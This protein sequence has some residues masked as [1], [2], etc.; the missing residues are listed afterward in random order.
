ME[1]ANDLEQYLYVRV[2][3]FCRIDFFLFLLLVLLLLRLAMSF[4]DGFI[5]VNYFL[6]SF[7]QIRL[8]CSITKL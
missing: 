7:P 1:T 5:F 8:F 3:P 4:M 6:Q 2:I